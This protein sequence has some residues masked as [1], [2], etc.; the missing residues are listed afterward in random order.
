MKKYIKYIGLP[1]VYTGVALLTVCYIAGWTNKNAPL[2]V[3][4]I[5]IIAGIAGHIYSVKKQSKY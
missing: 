3:G 1:L 4:I 5:L 2:F